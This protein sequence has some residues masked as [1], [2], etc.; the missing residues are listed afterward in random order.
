MG[1]NEKLEPTKKEEEMKKIARRSIVALD[2]I[3]E[4]EIFD[5]NNVGIR[6]PGTGL[7][8]ELYEKILQKRATRKIRKGKLIKHEDFD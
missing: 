6:R 7:S 8:P 2:D 5:R 4:N 1:G 3:D